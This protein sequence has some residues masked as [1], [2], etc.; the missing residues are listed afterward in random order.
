MTRR[1]TLR[2]GVAAGAVLSLAAVGATG[3][4]A[5]GLGG[6]PATPIDGLDTSFD[7]YFPAHGDSGFTVNQYVLDLEYAPAA[8]QLSGTAAVRI[9][10]F[11]A[12]SGF[13]LDCTGPVVDSVTVDGVRARFAQDAAAGK[14]HITPS[15][16]LAAGRLYTVVLAYRVQF[17]AVAGNDGW[18]TL[19]DGAAVL[20]MPIGAPTW[21]PCADDPTLKAAYDVSLTLPASP[22]SVLGNGRLV[23]TTPSADATM[24]TWRYRHDGP[25][26]T[27]LATLQIGAFEIVAQDGPAGIQLRNAYPSALADSAAY[28]LGRQGAMITA[29]SEL[30]GDFP[31]DA[32][33][34]CIRAGLP[35]AQFSAQT[36]G[37]LDS[38]LIDGRRSG[39]LEVAVGV[40]QQW[41]GASCSPA[42]WS[43]YWQTSGMSLHVAWVWQEKSG[44]PSAY[45]SAQQAMAR[46]AALP[47]D[48]VTSDPGPEH[49]TAPQ[50][51]LRAACYLESLRT[52]IGD[53]LFF[54]LMRL[55]AQHGEGGFQ[56]YDEWIQLIPTVYGGVDDLTVPWLTAAALPAL[57]ARPA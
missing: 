2:G 31:F 21:F 44:G 17:G 20:A 47:Q 8:N 33:G 37:L 38:T 14:V 48:I 22:F 53:S 52:T 40:A 7:P 45:Q 35:V 41:F 3:G 43:D 29:M 6:V 12:L 27:Y 57:A 23:G 39:E 30:Y 19:A 34:T 10:P 55:W 4:C 36:L 50:V 56:G 5:T 13:S 15:C 28:D 26:A 51:G 54:E 18:L 42:R 32:Y 25:M 9:Q 1:S 49:L 11:A 46:L 24:R 16:P